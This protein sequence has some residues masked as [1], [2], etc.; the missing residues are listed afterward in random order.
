MVSCEKCMR[1]IEAGEERELRAKLL[2]DDCYIDSIWPR[3]RKMYYE[4]DP[5]EFMRRLKDSYSIIQQQ[6]H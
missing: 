4:N 3:V 6:Y 2:C 5:A 1:I